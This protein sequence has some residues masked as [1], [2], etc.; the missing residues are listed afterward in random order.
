MTATPLATAPRLSH[1]QALKAASHGTHESLDQRIMRAQP[2]ASLANY[3]RFLQVQLRFHQ[4]IAPL[5]QHAELGR[6]L[7]DLAQ[8]QRLQEIGLDLMDLG[9]PPSP[10]SAA[11]WLD[12]VLPLPVALGWF[13]VAE[14]SNL[15]A[16]VL[17][18]LAA[19]L[20]LDEAKGARH[21]A[22][23][24]D[25]RMRHWRAFTGMLDGLSLSPAE[26]ALMQA[27]ARAAFERVHAHVAELL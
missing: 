20:G 14:G 27:S 6:L 17:F 19:K 2:F 8:R 9:Q 22:G 10:A 1:S 12:G 7:P 18:K 24:Q 5:Y 25:G 13:Y 4:D 15:G 23:H 16:A 3:Q 11:P 21:L 26:Q